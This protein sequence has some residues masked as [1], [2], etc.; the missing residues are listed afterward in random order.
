MRIRIEKTAHGGMGIGRNED[1]KI[2][3][4]D[5]AL[6]GDLVE[7][8]VYAE[9]KTFSH[10]RI[11]IIIEPGQGRRSSEDPQR[12]QAALAGAGCCD[13]DFADEETQ[14]KLKKEILVEQM[15]RI[16]KIDVSAEM[17]VLEPSKG[18]RTRARLAYDKGHIGLRGAKSHKIIEQPCAQMHPALNE[19]I[20]KARRKEVSYERDKNNIHIALDISGEKAQ[21]KTGKEI[22]HHSI[23]EYYFDLPAYSFWQAHS[24]AA[25]FYNELI[26]KYLAEEKYGD[27]V[28]V[29]DLY[30]GSGALIP[31]VIR[32]LSE[33]K[34]VHIDSVDAYSIP[35]DFSQAPENI[36]VQFHND[37][38]EKWVENQDRKLDL[39]ILDPP[40]V[41]MARTVARAVAAYEPRHII[42]VGCDIANFARDIRRWVEQGY[43]L[44][45]LDIVDAFPGTHHC[46][47]FALLARKD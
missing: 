24:A 30:G 12:C 43:E 42:H 2:I 1:N 44:K 18:W 23:G 25:E 45:K 33:H 11:L 40:R 19:F 15:R 10:A 47:S 22:I 26:Y 31:G 7:V 37:K 35:G 39:V 38:V 8:E 46:E 5:Q 9:K 3:F 16:A 21:V 41:G 6:P 29:W 36:S 32:A 28:R 20:D 13:F 34:N 17:H 4:V 14:Q 27:T